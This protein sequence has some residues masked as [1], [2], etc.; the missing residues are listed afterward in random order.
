MIIIYLNYLLL[1]KYNLHNISLLETIITIDLLTTTS[2]YCDRQNQLSS[3]DEVTLK[4]I[5]THTHELSARLTLIGR[6]RWPGKH[7]VW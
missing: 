7:V 4:H 1:L 5:G 6:Q 2:S 3:Q